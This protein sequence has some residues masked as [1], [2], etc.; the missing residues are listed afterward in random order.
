[1]GKGSRAERELVNKLWENGF[2]VMRSPASGSGR[3]HPQPDILVS[4]GNNIFGI[5]TKSTSSDVI[6]VKKNEIK[7]LKEFCD[8]FG[9]EALIGIRFDWHGWVF[10]IPEDCETTE[11]SYKIT[12]DTAGWN[13]VEGE[14][15][16]KQE[17]I[18]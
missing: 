1:M 10:F 13:L 12:K 8:K 15:F 6:Y 4:D 3:K 11:N 7:K 9:C 14:G 17:T 18:S 16:R 2:A 5:E